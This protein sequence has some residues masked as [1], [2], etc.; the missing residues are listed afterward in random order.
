MSTYFECISTGFE[1]GEVLV[2]KTV[3]D[4]NGLTR[5][6]AYTCNCSSSPSY[7]PQYSY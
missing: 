6:C 3:S 1:G 2:T 7:K 4:K 5:P